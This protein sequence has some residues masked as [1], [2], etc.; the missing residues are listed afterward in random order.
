MLEHST[1]LEN[2]RLPQYLKNNQSQK[3]A[4]KILKELKIIDLA[5]QKVKYLSGGQKQRV[6]IARE[7]MKNPQVIIADEPTSALDEKTSKATMDLL[8]AIAKNRTVIVV[9]HDTTLMEEQDAVYAL[10]KGVLVSGPKINAVKVPKIN[11]EKEHRLSLKN[12]FNVAKGSIKSKYSRFAVSVLTLVT[13]S[14]LLLSAISGAVGSSSQDEFDKLRETYGEAL[15]DI[16]IYNSFF[17]AAAADG[18]ERDQ[19]SASVQQDISGL[20]DQYAKDERVSF[21]AYLQAFDNIRITL[22]DKEHPIK[23]SGSVPS[24]N[25][26]VAGKM[27]MGDENEVVVPE[28]MVKQWGI[29]PEEAVGKT[30][31]FDGAI[32]D[33]TEGNPVSKEITSTA[34]I[35]GVMDTTIKYDYAGQ[36]TE[37]TVDDAFL[38]SKAALSEM[39]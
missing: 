3:S 4:E 34:E 9:T 16:G 38:F 31:K 5:D 24:I 23:S 28:S 13:A 35:V 25:Q 19:P 36:M 32:M 2:V 11:T 26:L 20:Y 30:I 6:A 8:R 27:P 39:Q 7:L 14:V 18:A 1:V 29:S 21:V 22:D 12:A 15:N 17:D 33:W 37:Y 10:D